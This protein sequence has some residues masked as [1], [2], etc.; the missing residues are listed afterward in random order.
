MFVIVSSLLL[1]TGAY[2]EQT[3]IKFSNIEP[4]SYGLLAMNNPS[5]PFNHI[6]AKFGNGVQPEM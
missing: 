6:P 4:N 1:L 3:Y 2:A 5:G